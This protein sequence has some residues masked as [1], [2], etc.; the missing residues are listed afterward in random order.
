MLGKNKEKHIS[1]IL[2]LDE[3]TQTALMLL[4]EK[5]LA[6]HT[7]LDD[8]SEE[9]MIKDRD[10]NEY[11]ACNSQLR[12]SHEDQV[13]QAKL[14]VKLEELEKENQS[15]NHRITELQEEK[16]TFL[17]KIDGLETE[18]FKKNHEIKFLIENRDTV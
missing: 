2:T 13:K 18:I 16:V 10:F 8:Q 11:T 3:T 14:L 7:T 1:A 9:V 17:N 6:R 12:L 5:L 4:I 15:L